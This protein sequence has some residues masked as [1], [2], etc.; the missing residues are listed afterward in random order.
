MRIG[1]QYIACINLFFF[2]LLKPL[3]LVLKKMQAFNKYVVLFVCC[4]CLDKRF[5][6]EHRAA[7]LVIN[8]T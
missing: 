2:F 8:D 6:Y 1:V 4:V 5:T 7:A 3:N